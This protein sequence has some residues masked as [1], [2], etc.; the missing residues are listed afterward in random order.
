MVVE[1]LSDN[2]NIREPNLIKMIKKIKE[3]RRE[4]K[5][6]ATVPMGKGACWH[7]RLERIRRLANYTTAR[8]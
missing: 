8:G 6:G 7:Q 2:Y 1:G 5:W 4:V 3:A